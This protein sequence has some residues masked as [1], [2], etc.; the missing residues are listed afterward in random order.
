MNIILKPEQEQFIQSQ[1]KSGRFTDANE[2][3]EVAFRLLEELND[4]YIQWVEETRE[5]V[6]VALT[7]IEQGQGLDGETVV[8]EIIERFKKAREETA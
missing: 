2:V 3:I 6:N 7:E 8:T 4:E 5:K 1:I